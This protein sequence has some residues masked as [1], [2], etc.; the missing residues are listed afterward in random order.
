MSVG[1]L[2]LVVVVCSCPSFVACCLLCVGS[3]FVVRCLE[4]DVLVFVD[5]CVL[6]VLSLVVRCS[7]FDV[8]C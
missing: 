5:C 4:Y 6:L 8:S 1:V 7:L 3:L 2:W